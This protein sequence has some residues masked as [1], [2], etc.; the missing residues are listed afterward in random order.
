MALLICD[1]VQCGMGRTGKFLAL[2][3]EG[4]VEP[5]MVL[6]SKA[7]SGGYVPLAA[8]LM[9][10]AIFDAVFT[11]VDRALSTPRHSANRASP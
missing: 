2:H 1:E 11:S 9:R 10:R 3:H 6:L 4:A 7:L 5:D 8:V